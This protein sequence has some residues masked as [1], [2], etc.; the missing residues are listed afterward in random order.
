MIQHILDLQHPVFTKKICSR[1]QG[2]YVRLSF[3]KS[4]SHVVEKCLNSSDKGFAVVDLVDSKRLAQVAHDQ[5][6]NYV[7]QTA[8]KVT[9]VT[10]LQFFVFFFHLF[11]LY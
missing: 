1:L 11:I 8:L 9:Q 10:S 2:Y 5:F 4:G 7:I 3:Q 6:G